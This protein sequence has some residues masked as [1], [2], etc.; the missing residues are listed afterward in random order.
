METRIQIKLTSPER[1]ALSTLANED[2][3][4][5]GDEAR[6]II[7]AELIQRGLLNSLNFENDQEVLEGK[8][9]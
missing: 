2:L 3:R 5:I 9:E 7:R 8:N 6:F 1:A 4:E